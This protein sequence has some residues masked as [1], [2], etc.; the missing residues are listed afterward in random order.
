MTTPADPSIS[1]GQALMA[2]Y[3]E[4]RLREGAVSS[5]P[6]SRPG[7]ASAKPGGAASLAEI[8]FGPGMRIR[9]GHLGLH[10][11]GDLAAAD[12]ARLRLA[13]GD[14]SRLIDVEAWISSAR[15]MVRTMST[16]R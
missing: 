12:A 2:A 7:G 14:I 13:L 6:A 9:L 8:G 11:V 1:K 4:A 3:R 10:S 15:E 16:Q 5:T